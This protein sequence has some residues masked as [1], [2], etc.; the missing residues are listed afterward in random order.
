MERVVVEYWHDG[1]W[2]WTRDY[3]ISLEADAV[4]HGRQLW[5]QGVAGVRISKFERKII[6]EH[7]RSPEAAVP[8]PHRRPR[9][10]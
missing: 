4:E 3:P 1:G 10:T 6:A 2:V 9:T 8:A 7:R 5:R